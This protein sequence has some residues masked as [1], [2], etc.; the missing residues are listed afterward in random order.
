MS[1]FSIDPTG[2]ITFEDIRQ[3][4]FT[5]KN[6]PDKFETFDKLT[7]YVNSPHEELCTYI[8][9]NFYDNLDV[10]YTQYKS[11]EYSGL[12]LSLLPLAH[13]F[14]DGLTSEQIGMDVELTQ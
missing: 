6:T 10:D 9:M 13:M 4:I 11:G 3:L 2:L 12:S 7:I 8:S 14:M 1:A 5:H